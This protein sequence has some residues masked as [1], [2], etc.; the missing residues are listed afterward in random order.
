METIETPLELLSDDRTEVWEINVVN[1]PDTRAGSLRFS[2]NAD[3][4]RVLELND[5]TGNVGIGAFPD[6]GTRLTVSQ[7]GSRGI[8]IGAFGNVG[9]LAINGFGEN[10]T[11]GIFINSSTSPNL[12]GSF[13]GDV[14]ITGQLTVGSIVFSLDSPLD[15]A[16]KSLNHSYIGSSE[17]LNVYSGNA[18]LDKNGE[19]WVD[20]PEWVE[21]L[22]CDFRYQLTCIGG[23]SSVY[24]A[25]EVS[26]NRFKIAGST[27]GMKVSWQLTGVRQDPWA[28]ANPLVADR[29]KSLKEQGYY[30]HPQFYD[31]PE[32]ANVYFVRHPEVREKVKEVERSNRLVD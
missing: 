10:A 9:I 29:E 7:R 4:D 21:A 2:A 1:A 24:I 22:N 19:A 31:Q 17:M 5:N 25:E 18:V 11:A 32:V 8:G 23:S 14:E 12:A 13:F 28:Q 27:P 20:L 16:T 3:R 6:L 15:P 30:Q 26:G